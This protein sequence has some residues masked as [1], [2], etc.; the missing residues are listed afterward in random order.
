MF[1]RIYIDRDE[2][3]NIESSNNGANHINT[4]RF[5]VFIKVP[6]NA[7]IIDTINNTSKID[8]IHI[9]PL[10]LRSDASRAI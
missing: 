8:N 4:D 6:D 5:S 9:M 7:R 2:H 1:K 3:K 10:L